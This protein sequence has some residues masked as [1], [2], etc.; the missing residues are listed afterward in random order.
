MAGS[1]PYVNCAGT[2]IRKRSM[3]YCRV[4][5]SVSTRETSPAE[6]KAIVNDASESMKYFS[7]RASCGD[8]INVRMSGGGL[9]VGA[10]SCGRSLV[11]VRHGGGG[12]RGDELFTKRSHLQHYR[13]LDNLLDDQPRPLTFRGLD[14][15]GKGKEVFGGEIAL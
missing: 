11:R 10:T 8:T 1:R 12:R 7:T 15:D 9:G 3:A 4:T 2:E 14:V 13:V 6:R 5:L